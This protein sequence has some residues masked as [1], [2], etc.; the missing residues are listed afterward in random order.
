M[1]KPVSKAFLCKK[2]ELNFKLGILK[3]AENL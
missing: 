2:K 3:F 1:Q